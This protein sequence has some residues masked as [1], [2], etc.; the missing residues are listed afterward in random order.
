MTLA[1]IRLDTSLPDNPQLLGLLEARE[2]HRAAFVYVCGLA[3]SGKHGLEGLIP[4]S[5]LG[6]INGRS[7]DAKQLVAHH[8]WLP[9][10]GGWEING[11]SEFQLSN[12]ETRARR[13]KAQKAANI[14]WHGDEQGASSAK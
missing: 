14:R 11:W 9:V 5:C 6:R 8:F 3:Y 1:W 7:A 2:G 12:D 13:S 10:M 4:K